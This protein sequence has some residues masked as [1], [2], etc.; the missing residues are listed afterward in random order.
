MIFML[1]SFGLCQRWA[2]VLTSVCRSTFLIRNAMRGR[3]RG[4]SDSA[5]IHYHTVNVVAL[6]DRDEG[7]TALKECISTCNCYFRQVVVDDF[8]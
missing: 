6:D 2:V 4:V 3:R 1:V 7:P 8:V 5:V